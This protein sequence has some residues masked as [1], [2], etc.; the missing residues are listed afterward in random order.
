MLA[1][2]VEQ[3]Q[4]DVNARGNGEVKLDIRE[5]VFYL[6]TKTIEVVCAVVPAKELDPEK[7]GFGFDEQFCERENAVTDYARQRAKELVVDPYELALSHLGDNAQMRIRADNLSPEQIKK[8]Q[9]EADCLFKKVTTSYQPR[10]Q[11]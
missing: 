11:P 9:G 3:L 5:F 1:N 4:K 6:R 8:E 7:R 2:I 10:H